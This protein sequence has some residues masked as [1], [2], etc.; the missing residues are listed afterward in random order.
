MIDKR[1]TKTKMMYQVHFEENQSLQVGQA[2]KPFV[3][4]EKS[5]SLIFIDSPYLHIEKKEFS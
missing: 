5:I 2:S 3:L 4:V 1:K